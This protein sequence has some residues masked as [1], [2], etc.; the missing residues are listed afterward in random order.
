MST[1]TPRRAETFEEREARRALFCLVVGV[2]GGKRGN[3]SGEGRGDV[4][5]AVV[6]VGHGW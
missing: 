5:F 3:I 4:L 6:G 2:S 1:V